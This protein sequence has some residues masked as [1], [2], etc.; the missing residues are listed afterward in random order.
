MI[1]QQ[2][3]KRAAPRAACASRP[4]MSDAIA[5]RMEADEDAFLTYFS[6]YLKPDK[7]AKPLQQLSDLRLLLSSDRSAAA[8][9]CPPTHLHLLRLRERGCG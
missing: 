2:L 9:T 8:W 5:R 3:I 7:M 1:K 4:Q 6:K